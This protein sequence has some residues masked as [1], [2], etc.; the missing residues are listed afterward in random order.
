MNWTGPFAAAIGSEEQESRLEIK[1]SLTL[2]VGSAHRP[3][4]EQ[5]RATLSTVRQGDFV[6][7]EP[8]LLF[9]SQRT[10]LFPA[11]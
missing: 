1:S 10:A 6:L 11:C 9:V 2:N 3:I 8:R 7:R 5:M 4:Q